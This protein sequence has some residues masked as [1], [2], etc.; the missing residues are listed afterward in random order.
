[1][2]KER[3]IELTAAVAEW[4]TAADHHQPAPSIRGDELALS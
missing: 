2:W 3:R 1:M 4:S